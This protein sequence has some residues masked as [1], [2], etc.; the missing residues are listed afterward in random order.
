MD[1]THDVSHWA[2][3]DQPRSVH[4]IA[5]RLFPAYSIKGGTVHLAG[6]LLENRLYL[7]VRRSPGGPGR[8]LFVDPSG[9]LVPG[10]LVRNLGMTNMR[11]LEKPLEP[12]EDD[13][14][15]LVETARG[16]ARRYWPGPVSDGEVETGIV[17]C[18]FAEGKLRF[19]IGESWVD[20]PF[21]GWAR[22]LVAPPFVCPH[23]GAESFE[24]A[25]T[26]DGRI[27][28][29]EQIEACAETGRWALPEDLVACSVTRR[30]VLKSLTVACP[31]S[32][33]RLLASAAIECDR[34]RQRVSPHAVERGACA[35]CR[36][37]RPVSKA[38]PRMARILGEFP[39]LDRFGSWRIAETANV[40]LLEATG[41]L[42]RLFLVID[43]ETLEA[44]R[45]AAGGRF[46][47]RCDPIDPS[48]FERFFG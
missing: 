40:Y 17:W 18:K 42:K 19:T 20:L 3:A 46:S 44:R 38:D 45:L 9:E 8:E 37:L 10:E 48:E 1:V 47:S 26:D 16:A 31:V 23:T 5:A 28:A 6:C 24:V 29:A 7:R 39:R 36:S 35:G 11:E 13:L 15:Q 21:S 25:A 43:K 41:W 34:C 33:E 30:R 12:I 32:G 27:V 22:T 14:S 2:P 4:E